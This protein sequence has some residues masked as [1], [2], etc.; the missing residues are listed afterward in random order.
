MGNLQLRN[1]TEDAV[2]LYM[3]RWYKE[4]GI[5][6]CEACR[7]DTMAIM[8]NTLAPK[9]VVTD[10]GALYAQLE[11]FDPQHKIDLMTVMTQAVTVVKNGPRHQD[12]R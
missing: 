9:Y 1:H 12:T 6:Q 3:D 10:K 5:C 7:L 8:L 2:R 4:S 11:D